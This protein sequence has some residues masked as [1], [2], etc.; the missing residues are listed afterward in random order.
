MYA[1]GR[2]DVH[3]HGGAL[4][5]KSRGCA[6]APVL[7]LECC[8]SLERLLGPGRCDQPTP[9]L[10]LWFEPSSVWEPGSR[11][12]PRPPPPPSSC[13]PSS[14]PPRPMSRERTYP[15]VT[16]PAVLFCSH[17]QHIVSQAMKSGSTIAITDVT[18]DGVTDMVLPPSLQG[19]PVFCVFIFVHVCV[20]GATLPL[21]P[22][23][24][25]SHLHLQHAAGV[26][27]LR[28]QQGGVVQRRGTSHAGSVQWRAAACEQVRSHWCRTT[29]CTPFLLPSPPIHSPPCT[30]TLCM[31]AVERSL[32]GSVPFSCPVVVPI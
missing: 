5:R 10:W 8:C 21:P 17:S 15:V 3:Q 9:S 26:V 6:F 4:L 1:L 30:G 2:H 7:P 19:V 31:Q 25:S 28:G 14:P 22:L 16:C 13:P 27:K 18:G 32:V 12:T 29:R 11:S 20:F 23:P 24:T